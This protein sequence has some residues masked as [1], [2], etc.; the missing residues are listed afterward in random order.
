MIFKNVTLSIIVRLIVFAATVVIFVYSFESDIW[1]YISS[2]IAVILFFEIYD[3]VYY[4][5]GIN[6]KLSYFFDAVRN[7]DTT[8]VFPEN[9]GS[10]SLMRLH[11]SMNNLNNLIS[12][13]KMENESSERFMYEL[14]NHSKTGLMSVDSYGYI[15][16]I[17][18]AAKHYLGIDNEINIHILKQVNP[19]LFEVLD[20]VKPNERRSIKMITDND[21]KH[22]VVQTSVL[23]F[24]DLEYRL[25]SIQDIKKEIDENE[26]DSY[27]KL[28]RVMTHEIMNSIAP[29]TSLSNTLNRFF[30]NDGTAKS[31]NELSEVVINNTIDGLTI[32]E[33]QGKA[34]KH[35]V[36]NYRKMT[37]IP[38]PKYN[39]IVV[40]DWLNSF[41]LLYKGEME[42]YSIKFRVAVD[43]R[44][45]DL[46]TD[47]KL[48]NQVIINV[49]KNA[50]SA[51]ENSKVKEI[52]MLLEI[53]KEGNKVIRITDSGCGIDSDLMDKIFIP[54]FTTKDNGDGIGLSLSRQ[55]IK[56][57]KGTFTV[58]SKKGE[59]TEVV[60]TL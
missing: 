24:K 32:I 42:E 27:Q 60:I 53:D 54:F 40:K 4:F 3:I 5:N 33:E 22:L 14:I 51:V 52:S 46:I 43:N 49:I 48:L 39:T 23:K 25:Y 44:F 41:A 34:L 8:L 18:T 2:L 1:Y 10:K 45:T 19:K 30:T 36:E 28:I 35:F 20:S 9:V 17:N 29:I 31:P 56:K 55:I 21:V 16:N 57:L 12:D 47:D 11:K 13:I 7:E 6:R 15:Q 59:G 50:M 38:Q 26:L 58:R 37:K